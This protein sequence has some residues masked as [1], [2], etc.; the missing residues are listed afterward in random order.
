MFGKSKY[1]I[2]NNGLDL[3][4][5]RFSINKRDKYRNEFGVDND[6]VVIGHVGRFNYQ[7]NHT[8]LIDIFEKYHEKNK[9]SELWLFG[10][11]ELED[12]IKKIVSQKKLSEFV[13][14][15]GIRGDINDIYSAI[16]CYVFP[17]LFEGM[18]NTVIEAQ[19]SG[20]PCIVSDTITRECNVTNDV[21]FVSN[22]DS[23]DQWIKNIKINNKK[24]RENSFE[25]LGNNKYGIE[26][27]V[28]MFEK[29]IF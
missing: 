6:T 26:A 7:K 20:L 11:G 25:Y 21:V 3:K 19:V 12:N 24:K 28:K 5:Y 18:P 15:Y 8:L 9:H 29:V 27:V 13:K 14:F 22:K 2:I 23:I 17:S 16:D 4:D 1:V 10:K